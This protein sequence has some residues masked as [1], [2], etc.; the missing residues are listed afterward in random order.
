MAATVAR[1]APCPCGSGLRFKECH[2]RLDAAPAS[3]DALIARAL[4]LHQQG[5]IDDAQRLYRQVLAADT[6]NAIATHYLG[7]VAW[8]HG[9]AREA[10]RL[11]RESLQRDASIPDFHNN[12]GLL[13]RD[14]RR[15]DEALACFSRT[16]EADPGWIEAY[17][18]RALTLEAAGRFDEALADYRTA[19]EREPRFAA[20]HQNLA[21][22][23]LM[24]GELAPAWEHYRWR[25]V[26]QGLS[27]S[28]PDPGASRLPPD[29]A[30]RRIALVAEQG[31]G[32]VLF[33][34]RFAPELK[35]RGATLAFEGEARLAPLLERTALFEPRIAPGERL[36]IGDLPWLLRA[37]DPRAFPPLPLRPD[38]ARAARWRE[39]LAA[40]GPPPYVALTWRAGTASRGPVRTQLKEVAPQVL[41]RAVEARATWISVQ[42]LPRAGE[43]EALEGALGARVHDAAAANE[44][45]EEILALMSVVDDYVGVSNANAHLRAGAGGS[46][47]VLVPFPP[48]WR[49][50]ATG[51]RSPWFP[52]MRVVRQQPDGRW[53]FT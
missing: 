32:D 18:N 35:R 43:R 26:A 22:L 36:H 38:A 33:F 4:Q 48:E 9:D 16:L 31:L 13:L 29:L 51:D 44:D 15:T 14:T 27:P 52:T 3:P 34:L 46:M 50:M 39:T 49:W 42:R 24:R 53:P 40:W 2:G 23:L 21:R 19:L 28:A 17:N 20:A 6:G 8:Q 11:M 45:L 25:L 7:M 1:N 37:D 47:R 30:G 41:A 10:E 12:L 5:R